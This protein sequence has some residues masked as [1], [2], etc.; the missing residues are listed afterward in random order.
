MCSIPYGN[1][2]GSRQNEILRQYKDSR[3]KTKNSHGQQNKFP[4]QNKESHGKKKESRGKT[5]ISHGK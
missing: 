3:G 2:Q 5:K 4:R 1:L